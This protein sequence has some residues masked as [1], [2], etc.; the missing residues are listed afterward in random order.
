MI[1]RLNGGVDSPANDA[2][3]ALFGIAD[4]PGFVDFLPG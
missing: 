2:R 4:L 3:I 1:A